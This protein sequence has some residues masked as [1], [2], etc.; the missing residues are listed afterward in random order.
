MYET[1]L[2]ILAKEALIKEEENSRFRDYLSG[3][4][5]NSLDELVFILNERVSAAIDCTLCGACCRSLMIN[6]TGAEVKELSRTLGML[7]GDFK[8]KY[9]EESA[10]G[11]FIINQ[12]PC[13]FLAG[14]K[15]SI[16][17]NRFTECREFPHL[18]KPHFKNRL[19][20]TLM[21]YGRC[22]IIYN[23]IEELKKKLNWSLTEN[24]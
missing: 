5:Q 10:Q 1:D 15:C 6:V 8:A 7:P 12:I 4:D 16:Y 21:H 9:I 17:A 24:I 18:H 14:G 22:P 11:H 3:K 2:S 13:H 23:V 19:F 20:G